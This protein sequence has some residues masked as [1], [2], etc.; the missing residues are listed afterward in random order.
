MKQ[1]TLILGVQAAGQNE[2]RLSLLFR[3]HIAYKAGLHPT[4]MECLELVLGNGQVTPGFLSD[5]T[6]LSTGAMTAVLDRLEAK[7][8][9]SRTRSKVDRRKV[10]ITPVME[11]INTIT[12]LYLPFVASANKLLEQYTAEQL[13]IIRQH[14]EAMAAIYEEQIKTG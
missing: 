13:Q 9:I 4:D 11:N 14:Y 8:L 3:H 10:L 2:A 7:S 12:S 6:G 5:N 1:H